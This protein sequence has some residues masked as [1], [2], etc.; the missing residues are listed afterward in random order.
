MLFSRL[1]VSDSFET[2]WTVAH[3][4]PPSMGFP[5]QQYWSG[6]AIS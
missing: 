1:V 3:Q 5:R 6:V 4:I 2:L